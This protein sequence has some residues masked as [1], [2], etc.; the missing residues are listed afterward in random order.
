[1]RHQ[2]LVDSC[3]PAEQCQ[4]AVMQCAQ[5][6]QQHPHLAGDFDDVQADA[7]KARNSNSA[8]GDAVAR[9]ACPG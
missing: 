2:S 7:R 6:R 3:R 9:V 4:D 5:R 8:V 1:M